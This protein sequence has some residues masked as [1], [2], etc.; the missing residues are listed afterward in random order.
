[1]CPYQAAN[2]NAMSQPS[3]II[4][5]SSRNAMSQPSNINSKMCPYQVMLLGLC[6]QGEYA[7]RSTCS[8]QTPHLLTTTRGEIDA[9]QLC[10]SLSLSKPPPTGVAASSLNSKCL[11][12]TQDMAP[13]MDGMSPPLGTADRWKS[14]SSRI[15]TSSQEL[16]PNL[17]GMLLTSTAGR[18]M[19]I[20]SRNAV[21]NQDLPANLHGTSL[22]S[23]ASRRRS[24]SS[25]NMMTTQDQ[26]ANSNAMSL[27]SNVGS[28]RSTSSKNMMSTQDRTASSSAMSRPSDIASTSSRNMCR[29]MSM[30]PTMQGSDLAFMCGPMPWKP[31]LQHGGMA[32]GAASKHGSD[33]AVPGSKCAPAT[34]HGSDACRFPCSLVDVGENEIEEVS[35]IA[36]PPVK[37]VE[38]TME[39]SI[40]SM[41][42]E[43]E[44]AQKKKKKS[45]LSKFK[46][47]LKKMM[48]SM[49]P[50]IPGP[51]SNGR[52]P[53][54][55]SLDSRTFSSNLISVYAPLTGVPGASFSAQWLGSQH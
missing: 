39:G 22:G 44:P 9:A 19:S 32:W 31:A 20:G 26:A 25:R 8:L 45:L 2:S 3:N 4:S 17:F 51:A 27:D 42:K 53:R 33:G 16:S 7:S 5:T 48:F 21:P 38:G 54:S 50:N 47:T 35:G 41:E 34:M 23:N 40:G 1:M 11:M 14:T 49:A 10:N 46:R 12:S 37:V 18:R 28:R 55:A 13:Y 6:K 52:A 43:E 24:I 29:P 30:Q 36:L 15:F